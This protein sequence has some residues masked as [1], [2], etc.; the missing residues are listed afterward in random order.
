MK[1]KVGYLVWVILIMTSESIF[2]APS[3]AYKK[4]DEYSFYINFTFEFAKLLPYPFDF[5]DDGYNKYEA[6]KT[7]TA[8]D[9]VDDKGS[10]QSHIPFPTIAKWFNE[11]NNCYIRGDLIFDCPGDSI[12]T[13][14]ESDYNPYDCQSTAADKKYSEGS[15]KFKDRSFRF[16]CTFIKD[17]ENKL[18][19]KKKCTDY[20]I[21]VKP[22][23]TGKQFP[24][25]FKIISP[26]SVRNPN[27]SSPSPSISAKQISEFKT[28]SILKCPEGQFVQGI[29]S[30]HGYYQTKDLKVN[31]IKDRIYNI[32]C[33]SLEDS[34]KKAYV[35]NK[36]ECHFSRESQKN[37]DFAAY[38]RLDK[39][40]TN[41]GEK[42]LYCQNTSDA[43][44]V[45][46]LITSIH[47]K[48]Q[49]DNHYPDRT[50]KLQCCT[51]TMQ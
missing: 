47:T 32:S 40:P 10:C 49:A 12:M 50:F 18:I 36:N 3:R 19:R 25:Y 51:A 5:R 24:D 4:T 15:C 11:D 46:W 1:L 31:K 43:G 22:A 27:S 13:G 30:Y 41:A 6:L 45:Q 9:S 44:A 35:A 28:D 26:T 37:K 34:N 23:T 20:S 33:C 16:R 42:G 29:R 48:Y 17:V 21:K 2:S 38:Q 14:I 39:R 8:L 7:T